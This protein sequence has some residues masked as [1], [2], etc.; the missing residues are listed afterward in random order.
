MGEQRCHIT[1]LNSPST[2]RVSA[3]VNCSDG[4][5]NANFLSDL[6]NSCNS[7]QCAVAIDI[8]FYLRLNRTLNNPTNGSVSATIYPTTSDVEASLFDLA[9]PS[10]ENQDRINFNKSSAYKISD[11]CT[12]SCLDE[13]DTGYWG[14]S[15][16]YHCVDGTLPGCD[17]DDYPP[18][19]TVIRF[20]AP[21]VLSGANPDVADGT[22]SIVR[23]SG[24]DD[25]VAPPN[26][27][28]TDVDS[29]NTSAAV[30]PGV[31]VWNLISTTLLGA[32]MLAKIVL[33][34]I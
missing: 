21:G 8:N 24:C 19:G 13:C 12:Q 25:R 5:V 17:G 32:T 18:D 11:G 26:A 7:T 14:F 30:S 31:T 10:F 27:T 4:G 23:C 1:A 20:C 16:A 29:S 34:S 9:R 3:I 6:T 2:Y 22:L 28:Q 33:V 15:P